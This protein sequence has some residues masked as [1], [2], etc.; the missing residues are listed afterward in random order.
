[1][2][3]CSAKADQRMGCLQFIRHGNPAQGVSVAGCGIYATFGKS[4]RKL[5]RIRCPIISAAFQA[6]MHRGIVM[7]DAVC[8]RQ[9]IWHLRYLLRC[10][11]LFEES[12][13]LRKHHPSQNAQH[14]QVQRIEHIEK[15]LVKRLF[16][17]A[18]AVVAV[19]YQRYHQKDTQ[20]EQTTPHGF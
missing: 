13:H 10:F 18:F 2:K 19:L 8:D 7:A 1:M 16:A 12:E 11:F 20:L 3:S 4:L 6:V 17:A 5:R 9:N 14:Q 15:P